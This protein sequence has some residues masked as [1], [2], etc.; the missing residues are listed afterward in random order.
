MIYRYITARQNELQILDES[1]LSIQKTTRENL[2]KFLQ[3]QKYYPPKYGKSPVTKYK[4]EKQL[5]Y[6]RIGPKYFKKWEK[7][8][9]VVRP[10]MTAVQSVP[11]LKV[12]S[13]GVE[14]HD[15]LNSNDSNL[16]NQVIL[17]KHGSVEIIPIM[18]SEYNLSAL[19]KVDGTLTTTNSRYTVLS[20]KSISDSAR[21]YH[22]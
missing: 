14:I 4:K 19:P 2:K 10:W 13:K 17:N 21:K 16:N 18:H 6:N 1:E 20:H 12:Y 5:N 7:D 11:D 15:Y 22:K 9:K 3:E 8:V